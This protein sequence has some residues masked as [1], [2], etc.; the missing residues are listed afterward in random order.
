MVRKIPV[1][2]AFEL[3]IETPNTDR[4]AQGLKSPY[5]D[6]KLTPLGD[7]GPQPATKERLASLTAQPKV[8]QGSYLQRAIAS[9]TRAARAAA[10]AA[11][12]FA[13]VIANQAADKLLAPSGASPDGPGPA[14]SAAV[15]Q[16]PTGTDPMHP[17]PPATTPSF[18]RDTEVGRNV[19][20]AINA[21]PG[22]Q[23]VAGTLRAGSNAARAVDVA[24]TALRSAQV[25]NVMRKPEPLPMSFPPGFNPK[26]P[27]GGP[28][29]PAG[30]S[31]AGAGRGGGYEGMRT[32][33]PAVT[34][35]ETESSPINSFGMVPGAREY[36]ASQAALWDRNNLTG[37]NVQPI[38]AVNSIT[39]R[40]MQ[41]DRDQQLYTLQQA[42][43]HATSRA[44]RAVALRSYAD[45][46][47]QP[48][49]WEAAREGERRQVG[50]TTRAGMRER[51]ESTRAT[52][53]DATRRQI[54][55]DNDLVAL[56]GQDITDKGHLLTAQIARDAAERDQGNKN[57]EF[58]LREKE[59]GVNSERQ[60]AET[61]MRATE[62]LH[63]EIASMLPPDP[64]GKPDLAKA[65]V[66]SQG[67]QNAFADLLARTADPKL[68]A[69]LQAKGL[70]ALDAKDKRRIVAGMQLAEI[71]SATATGGLT[72]WGTR[73]IQ[74][75][76]P[77]MTL[78]KLPNGDYQ[79]NRRGINGE[80]EVIPARYVEKE[81]STWGFGG[82]AS[83][84][85]QAL[86]E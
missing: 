77:I 84:K 6:V 54:A 23:L 40:N 7:A 4:L 3:P 11:P 31:T 15:A 22:G 78:R 63:K 5:P 18:F 61:A 1:G 27:P 17:A 10:G 28:A 24:G 83:N 45:L 76:A 67:V 50:E 55:H 39:K 30:N 64:E 62:S 14:Q 82:R 41:F 73:A 66:Y 65:A 47:A 48:A 34:T 16:I 43:N 29:M 80:T 35:G 49:P 42:A 51:G 68:K 52:A 75:N 53:A 2:E 59:F 71:A 81:G 44:D 21:I 79:T 38:E 70:G 85:F 36:E 58:T 72:P 74:S 13:G 32:D 46:A 37:P 25:D 20:N 26:V 86:M 8:P 9:G 19:G 56:R 57:R 33:T 69:E 60:N 12:A